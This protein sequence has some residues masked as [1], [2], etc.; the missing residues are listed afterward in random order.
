[1][2]PAIKT[3]LISILIGLSFGVYFYFNSDHRPLRIFISVLSTVSIGSLI[4]LAICFRH[5]FTM[6]IPHQSLKVIFMIVLLPPTA[7]LSSEITFAVQSLLLSCEKY[8]PFSGRI[9]Y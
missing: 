1:M 6:V 9:F 2:H 8:H 4:I 5:Y 7:L 3:L